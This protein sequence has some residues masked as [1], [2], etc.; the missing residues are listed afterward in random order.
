MWFDTLCCGALIGNFQLQNPAP[1]IFLFPPLHPIISCNLS[2]IHNKKKKLKKKHAFIIRDRCCSTSNVFCDVDTQSD[3][4][5]FLHPQH[6]WIHHL[7][8]EVRKYSCFAEC[9]RECW[10]VWARI[11]LEFPL[12]V[13]S[14]PF[15]QETRVNNTLK[16]LVK[17]TVCQRVIW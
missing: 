3:M 15:I 12:N 1:S 13:T 8:R 10:W 2:T 14:H 17:V 16:K 11:L 5:H 6:G 4:I 9:C 7:C